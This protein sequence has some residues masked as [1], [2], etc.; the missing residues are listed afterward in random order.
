MIG[1]VAHP[2]ILGVGPAERLRCLDEPVVLLAVADREAKAVRERMAVAEGPRDQAAREQA[3]G[4]A[5][6]SLGRRE[7][8]EDEVRASTDGVPA[9]IATARPMNRSRS[10][11]IAATR[12][13]ASS[14]SGSSAAATP[15]ETTDTDPG[16]R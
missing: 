12:A 4:G 15:T 3:L 13:A 7:L 2:G 5:S 8:D 16:G 6:A 11:T 1:V 9:G 10:S 14:A